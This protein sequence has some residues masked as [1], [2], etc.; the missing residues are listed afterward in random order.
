MG[1]DIPSHGANG[2]VASHRHA[3]ADKSSAA[4]RRKVLFISQQCPWPKNSGG[5]IRSYFIAKHLSDLADV[6]LICTSPSDNEKLEAKSELLTFCADVQ[7]VDGEKSKTTLGYVATLAR[8][9]VRG[10]PAFIEHNRF[11]QLAQAVENLLQQHSFD[12]VHLNHVDTL[13]YVE[14]DDDVPVVLDTHNLNWEYYVRRAEHTS[15]P[16]MSALFSRD[17]RLLKAYE[18]KAFA[19]AKSVL[20]CSEN[21][22][23][24]VKSLDSSIN[25]TVVPNGVDCDEYR[26]FEGDAFDNEPEIIFIGDMGYAPN[27]DG[28]LEFINKVLPTVQSSVPDAKFTV[29]GRSPAQSLV[30]LVR[31][32]SDV[33]I[34]GFVEDVAPFLDKAKVFVVPLRFGAGTRL[35]IL[36][37]FSS[38]LPTVATSIGAEGIEYNHGEDILIAD[39]SVEMAKAVC[40][41]LS[42][43]EVYNSIR[44]NC[45]EK[46]LEKYDWNVVA[47]QLAESISTL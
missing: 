23:H 2:P 10:S 6:T 8:S 3:D 44:T 24:K 25:V 21:E 37:A 12:W 13:P 14:I 30:D 38:G 7:F 43:K 26:P 18:H 4:S 22:Y 1:D 19:R 29:V 32:R 15:N 45:R 47:R 27:H 42:D 34:T 31:N 33:E 36:Q 16:V 20:V 46:A 5:N 40:S 35:K 17:A 9:F 41:L 28:V 11:D 39:D